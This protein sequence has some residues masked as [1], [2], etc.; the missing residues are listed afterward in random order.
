MCVCVCINITTNIDESLSNFSFGVRRL[1][2]LPTKRCLEWEMLCGI[3]YSSLIFFYRVH[4]EALK[5]MHLFLHCHPHIPCCFCFLFCFFSIFIVFS[6]FLLA[7][8]W[9]MIMAS[10]SNETFY[11]CFAVQHYKINRNLLLGQ[12]LEVWSLLHVLFIY[13]GCVYVNHIAVGNGRE[14]LLA[15]DRERLHAV[16]ERERIYATGHKYSGV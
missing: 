7:A 10:R 6:N 8:K 4:A 9:V 11:F 16:L 2:I 13:F 1:G 5:S 12:G 3:D 15:W 14:A